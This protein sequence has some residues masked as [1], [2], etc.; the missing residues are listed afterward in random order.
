MPCVV[1][2][3]FEDE[4]GKNRALVYNENPQ[5]TFLG[6]EL[7]INETAEPTDIIWENREYSDAQRTGKT[8][9]A[10]CIISVMLIV[11]FFAIFKCSVIANT[12]ESMYPIANCG[13]TQKQWD[14]VM[15]KNSDE[16]MWERAAVIEYANNL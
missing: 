13:E 5:M 3:T 9:I 8:I 6:E 15:T 4:E 16:K 11:A 10:W 1:F 12:A 7:D 14:F 2:L